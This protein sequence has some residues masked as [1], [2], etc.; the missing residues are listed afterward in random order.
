METEPAFLADLRYIER[1]IV[2]AIS[3]GLFARSIFLVP[4]AN[5]T[6]LALA[7]MLQLLGREFNVEDLQALVW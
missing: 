6:Q 5:Q 1:E 2:V 3:L 7:R 4:S